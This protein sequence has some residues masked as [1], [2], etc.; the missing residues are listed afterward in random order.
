M[1]VGLGGALEDILSSAHHRQLLL[2]VSHDIDI[3]GK[4]E[5]IGGSRQLEIEE[6]G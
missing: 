6:M 2:E 5:H 1:S 4:G 3:D